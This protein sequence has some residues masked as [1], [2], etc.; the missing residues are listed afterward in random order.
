MYNVLSLSAVQQRA[1]VIHIY[2][3]SFA[4]IALS[5]KKSRHQAS[6]FYLQHFEQ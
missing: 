2:I 1:P 4:Y 5:A 3:H 6:Q